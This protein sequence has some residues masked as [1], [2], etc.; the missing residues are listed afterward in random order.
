MIL[1]NTM[2][3]NSSLISRAGANTEGETQ[4]LINENAS[5]EKSRLFT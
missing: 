2:I 3:N 4:S 5:A 1:Y